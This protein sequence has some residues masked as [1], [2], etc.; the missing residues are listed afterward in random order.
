MY[1]CACAL[2]DIINGDTAPMNLSQPYQTCHAE[3]QS[4]SSDCRMMRRNGDYCRMSEVAET[5]AGACACITQNTING[6]RLSRIIPTSTPDLTVGLIVTRDMT[7]NIRLQ[8][9]LQM[10]MRV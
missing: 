9:G 8:H 10:I 7:T 3:D 1:V 6:F 2:V 4:D 5:A